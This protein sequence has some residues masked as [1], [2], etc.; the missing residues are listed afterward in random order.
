MR[1]ERGATPGRSS[2]D[3]GLSTACLLFSFHHR[4]QTLFVLCIS[5]ATHLYEAFYPRDSKLKAIFTVGFTSGFQ[6]W[7]EASS[8]NDRYFD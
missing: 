1:D 4:P 2:S 7:K 6:L 3:F 8:S 5:P